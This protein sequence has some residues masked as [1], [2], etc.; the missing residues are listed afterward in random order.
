MLSIFA[1]LLISV[2][3]VRYVSNYLL[4][5]FEGFTY[6]VGDARSLVFSVQACQEV[7]VALSQVPGIVLHMTY[8][9][10]IS[11]TGSGN[12]VLRDGADGPVLKTAITPGILSCSNTRV[13]WISWTMNSVSFGNGSVAERNRILYH[14]NPSNPLSINAIS[15]MTTYGVVGRFSFENFVGN[16]YEMHTP[17]DGSNYDYTYHTL[18]PKDDRLSFSVKGCNDAHIMTQTV[19]G[20][21]VDKHFEIV[22]GGWTNTRSAIRSRRG[23]SEL[24]GYEEVGIMACDEYRQFWISW[25]N[26][27]LEVGKNAVYTQSFM[28]YRMSEVE[29]SNTSIIAVS[30]ASGFGSEGD[31]I[32]YENDVTSVRLNTLPSL[33]YNQLSKSILEQSSIVFRVQ[34]CRDAHVALSE[35]FNNIQTRTYEVIIGGYGNQN[36]FIR[37]LDTSTEVQKVE[38]PGIMDCNNYKA[39]W[40]RWADNKITVG[41][42]TVIGQSSFL[43]WDD[44]ERRNFQG[45]TFSTWTGSSGLW[46]FSYLEGRFNVTNGLNCYLFL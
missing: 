19:P 8:E 21:T 17:D 38:T 39:F 30:F 10:V 44:S 18:I 12:T 2:T 22:I 23:G 37:D 5:A 6:S 15:F 27:T 26:G 11:E 24:V 46:D 45:L 42:G 13:F 28:L 33:T 1:S 29:A 20:S 9:L 4:Q 31:W 25:R 40:V 41:R 43:D 32:V 34:S 35:M 16:I 7:H 3:A 36:S 14:T